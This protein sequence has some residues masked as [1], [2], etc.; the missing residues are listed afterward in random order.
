[1]QDRVNCFK[2]FH[3]R[4]TKYILFEFLYGP[5]SSPAIVIQACSPEEHCLLTEWMGVVS[6]IP[7]CE[8]EILDSISISVEK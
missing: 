2:F 5:V 1:M 8:K 7:L 3:L 4:K 6:G